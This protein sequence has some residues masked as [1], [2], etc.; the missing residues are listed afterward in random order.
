MGRWIALAGKIVVTALLVYWAIHSIDFA[1]VGARWAQLDPLW[2]VP[3]AALM[4]F[5]IVLSTIR[6]HCIGTSL[7]AAVPFWR[8]N[9]FNLI[10]NFFNQTLPSVVGG[11][12]IR[13]WLTRD[14]PGGLR[15]AIH[16]VL[17]DRGAGLLGILLLVAICLPGSWDVVS[18]QTG[19]TTL[20]FMVIGGV[21]GAGLFFLLGA[22]PTPSGRWFAPLAAVA[23]IAARAARVLLRPWPGLLVWSLSLLV[24]LVT[25]GIVLCLARGLAVA[26]TPLEALL[27]VPPVMLVTVLPVTVAGWGLR[28]G[29]MIAAL[30]YIGIPAEDALAISV[31]FGLAF[32]VLGAIGGLCWLASGAERP[33]VDPAMVRHAGRT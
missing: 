13:I 2:L 25:V 7:D 33:R 22:I 4:A 12:A 5:Q 1:A 23:Q 19:R 32:L 28:E 14:V 24:H 9:W 16:A 20:L 30:S 26:I 21:I 8:R 31:L 29:A 6:W 3:V 15:S 17:I 27:L 11:D 10:S 18:D